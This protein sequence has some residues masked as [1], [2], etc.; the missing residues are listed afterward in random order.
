MGRLSDKY[1]ILAIKHVSKDEFE[2]DIE[3]KDS[4]RMKHS[5]A[6]TVAIV[7]KSK[8]AIIMDHDKR[9]DIYRFVELLEAIKGEEFDIVIIEGFSRV[10]GRD[11]NIYKI[12]VGRD[13]GSIDEVRSIIS[14]PIMA[15]VSD[16]D[17]EES[18]V[19]KMDNI[20]TIIEAIEDML[21]R[22]K[23]E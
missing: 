5:G 12:I 1:K 10:L 11:E 16:A 20:E 19:L 4:W 17:V 2:I 23:R 21:A 8:L 9:F 3:G 22:M 14:G 18:K 6:D 7:S 15:I 13:L